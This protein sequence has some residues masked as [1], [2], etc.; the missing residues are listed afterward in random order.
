MKKTKVLSLILATAM[1]V[2][3]ACFAAACGGDEGGGGNETGPGTTYTFEAEG[4]DVTGLTGRGY[5]VSYSETELIIGKET[6]SSIPDNVASSMSNGFCIAYW[7]TPGT[8]LTFKINADK[9]SENNTITLRVSSEYGSL[10]VTKDALSVIVNDTELN[11]DPFTIVGEDLA[12]VNDW[13]GLAVPFADYKISAS[14][15]LKEGENVIK[16][17]TNKNKL[18]FEEDAFLDSVSPDLDCIK[19]RSESNLTWNSMWDENKEQM[20]LD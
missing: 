2:A 8:T 18:G 17:R 19:I 11:Y 1:L 20:G 16:I 6:T 14:F 3:V 13:H 4:I 12:S 7:N 15:P 5:S 9:A 10:D